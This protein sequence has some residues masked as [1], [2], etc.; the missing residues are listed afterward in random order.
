M[1]FIGPH[2]SAA[3][4][5]ACAVANA[6]HFGATGF[7]LFVKN[8]RQWV[9]RSLSES[10]IAGFRKALKDGGYTPAQVLP[11]AGY[12]INPANADPEKHAKSMNS[13]LDELHRCEQL[14]LD[15]LNIHPGAHLRQLSPEAA[16]D[17]VADSFN[18]ALA[19]TQGVSIIIE[20]TA[21]QGSYLGA[22]P[23][24][25]ARIIAGVNDKRRIGFCI[26]T[27]HALAAG[28]DIRTADGYRHFMDL[29]DSVIGLQYLRGMHLNDSKTELASHCDRHA[30]L[31]EGE[32]GWELFLT[33]ARDPRTQNIPLILETPDE[34]R[35]SDEIRTL[36]QA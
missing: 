35:W 31:G 18:Y 1:R 21:G 3:G 2:V 15:R 9:G 36:L 25:L 8:Q 17:R 23:E 33:I 6:L 14:G 34:T 11:H 30:S 12:L 10:D 4:S 13:L 7:G 32:I 26:D 20:N 29:L 28:Y 22:T 16:C 5:L 24:E 19:K 27:A